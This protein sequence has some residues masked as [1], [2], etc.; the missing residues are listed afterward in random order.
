M[1]IYNQLTT[2]DCRLIHDLIDQSDAILIGAGHGLSL[3]AGLDEPLPTDLLS[4][5]PKA[6]WGQAMIRVEQIR[7][8]RS[9][10]LLYQQLLKLLKDKAYFVIT[11]NPDGQFYTSGF[12][13]E[14]LYTTGGD[15]NRLQCA[16]NCMQKTMATFPELKR[17]T[18][19]LD[20]LTLTLK[21]P[22]LV[23]SC[24]DCGG[25]LT[26]NTLAA[27]PFCHSPYE[28]QAK[29]YYRFINGSAKGKLVILE[30][31]V[32]YTNPDLIRFPFEHITGNHP[33]VTLIRINTL[34]PLAV[35]ENAHKALSIQLDIKIAL[36]LLTQNT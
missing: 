29:R 26:F 16:H 11:T 33:Q 22:A 27:S 31:G 4:L 21:D 15:Y 2:T 14:R 3:A 19:A 34:H 23:P 30:L 17:I 24:P 9:P 32:G 8:A 13:S 1:S 5:T 18:A 7:F 28:E 20:P 35:L 36:D 12:N 10:N 25:P 6:Y